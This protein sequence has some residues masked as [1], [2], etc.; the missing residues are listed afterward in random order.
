MAMAA[1]PRSVD[2]AAAPGTSPARG[3]HPHVPRVPGARIRQLTVYAFSAD[4]WR[5]PQ[6]EVSPHAA[7]AVYSAPG[8]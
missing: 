7:F 5:R 3:P 2:C 8:G 1:G 4:N 6:E